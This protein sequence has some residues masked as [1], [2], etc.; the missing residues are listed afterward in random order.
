MKD[1][2]KDFKSLTNVFKKQSN[3]PT[4]RIYKTQMIN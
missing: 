4:K 2:K 1:V 3:S